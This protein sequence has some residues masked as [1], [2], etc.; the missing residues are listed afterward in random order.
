M[1]GGVSGN[2]LPT[3]GCVSSEDFYL[4]D[5]GREFSDERRGAKGGLQI[6]WME[7]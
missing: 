3:G 6:E 7:L 2:Y 1:L 4:R 5:E